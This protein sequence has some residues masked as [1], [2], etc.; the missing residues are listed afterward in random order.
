[1]LLA[2]PYSALEADNTPMV[3]EWRVTSIRAARLGL[4][5]I[6]SMTWVT[7]ALVDSRMLGWWLS[8][9]ETVW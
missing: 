9:R 7:R 3:R 2:G 6:S 8:T 1:M 5:W 4:Y